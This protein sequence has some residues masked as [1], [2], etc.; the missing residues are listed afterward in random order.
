MSI[1]DFQTLM[2]PFLQFASDGN[3]HAM[4]EARELL[5]AQFRLRPEE[6]TALLPGGRLAVFDNRV[7][8]AKVYLQRA[9]LLD[10]PRRG[11]TN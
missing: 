4:S 7:A 6:R 2:L 1:P 3:E 5:A 8:R 10:S 9:R 11:Q